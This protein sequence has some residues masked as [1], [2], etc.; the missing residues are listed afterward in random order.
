MESMIFASNYLWEMRQRNRL[1]RRIRIACV[2]AV[3]I[4]VGS[5]FVYQLRDWILVPHLT[6]D[7]P[8]DGGTFQGPVI[9]VEGTVT[10]HVRLT[11]NGV[12][13]YNE[14]NGSFHAELLLPAG[15]H[16]IRIIAE[17]RFGRSRLVERQVVVEE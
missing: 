6:I 10:P 2:M 1:R 12:S 3:S 7:Q 11:V 15:L 17:N 16:T 14:V 4:I 5:Y 9:T 13:V 8:A